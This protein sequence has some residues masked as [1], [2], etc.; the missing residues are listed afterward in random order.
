MPLGRAEDL[1]VDGVDAAQIALRSDRA[2]GVGRRLHFDDMEQQTAAEQHLEA[3]GL[4]KTNSE[5]R[6]FPL[7]RGC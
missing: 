4:A 5:N 6:H 7:S 3:D 2:P 1:S